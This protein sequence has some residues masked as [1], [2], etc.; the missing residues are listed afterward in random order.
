MTIRLA[1]LRLRVRTCAQHILDLRSDYAPTRQGIVETE[2]TDEL[3]VKTGNSSV[4]FLGACVN[5]LLVGQQ[6]EMANNKRKG[7]IRALDAHSV[8]KDT[9]FFKR[10]VT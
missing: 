3:V 10:T 4:H 1:R 2:Q 9:I 5:T 8:S 7:N 6:C